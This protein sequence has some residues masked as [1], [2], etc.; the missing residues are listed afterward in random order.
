MRNEM[1]YDYSNTIEYLLDWFDNNARILPWR[2]NPKPYYVW[3]SEIMLQQTRVEAV[4]TYFE[5]FIHALPT[6]NDL[7]EVEE[8]RLLKLWEGLGYY[9]RARN[10][11]RAASIVMDEYEGVLP[12]DYEELLK[13]PGIGSYTAGAITSIAYGNAR[14]AVD[15]NVLRVMKRIAGSFDDITNAK[16]KKELE[17]DL[18]GIMPK[19]RPGD[20]NQAIMELGA[21]ICIPNGKPLC[22]KCPVMHLC[23]AFHNRIEMDIPV[24][25][26][27][28]PR[29][30]ENV[31]VFVIEYQDKY[32]IRKRMNKGLLSGLWEF[33]NTGADL[34]Q[35][36]ISSYLVEGGLN[37]LQLHSDQIIEVSYLGMGKHIF[38]HIEWHMIGYQIKIGNRFVEEENIYTTNEHMIWAS[39]EEIKDIYSLPSAFDSFRKQIL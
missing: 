26:A 31:T 33:P 24:K 13:L 25:T 6:I 37:E 16:V 28:K 21:M 15:G 3:I 7:A 18:L 20:F 38:T 36:D 17:E 10:L 35:E 27:K 30:I 5:R 14:P 32:L 11:K 1:N 8:D 39:K 4:K 29:K 19:D 12:A 9:N 2:S 22:D 34:T 23:K